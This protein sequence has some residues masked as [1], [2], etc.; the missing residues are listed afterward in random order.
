MPT[1]IAKRSWSAQERI[2]F[3]SQATQLRS[4]VASHRT[5]AFLA[6]LCQTGLLHVDEV[7]RFLQEHGERLAGC[8]DDQSIG[9]ALVAAGLLS[10]YQLDRILAGKA[11][12]LVLGNHRVLGRLGAGGMG[13]VFLAEH[14]FM[15]RR[16]AV[17]VLGVDDDC[18]PSNVARFYSEMRVLAE[19]HHPNIVTAYDAGK[20]TA[21]AL[22]LPT[23]LY[24][25]MELVSGGDLEQH[26]N[27][28]GPAD[29][30]TACD[31][32]CQ[33]AMGIQ[34]AHDHKLIHRDIKPSNLLRTE[35]NEIK[36][37][38]FGLVRQF[39]NRMTDPNAL[40]GTIEFMA[41]EQSSGAAAVS[42]QVD[43]YGL[44][45]TLLWLLTG[46]TP[47]PPTKNLTEAVY[48]LNNRPPR[49]LREFRPDAPGELDELIDRMLHRDPMRRPA[50][51]LT[52]MRS[53][54]PFCIRTVA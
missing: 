52:V 47:Y 24:L 29:V 1:S 50:L 45:A 28:H 15:K 40:L 16:V 53:L 9:A 18:P 42:S 43:I 17:K 36:V 12:G 14:I 11:H 7:I 26:I 37:V 10:T 4:A 41:P 5:Q 3:L 22:S 48:M 51:P 34:E 19:L 6:G 38:D 35:A 32:V 13:V 20:L 21:P 30:P 54:R 8:K 27:D 49:R 39:S 25:V 23:L 44:G 46:Q 2:A 31:W 33:A